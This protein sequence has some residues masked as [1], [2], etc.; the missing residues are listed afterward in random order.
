MTAAQPDHDPAAPVAVRR[1]TT[2]LV[3]LTVL[4]LVAVPVAFAAT[5]HRL[6]GP[7]TDDVGVLSG[8]T[9]EIQARLDAL[10]NATKAQLW[11]W[12]TDTLQGADSSQFATATAGASG[13]GPTDL[14]LVV[15][16]ND[17]AYGW[18]KGNDVPIS[19]SDLDGVLS[20]E[21]ESGLRAGDEPGAVIAT[22][23]GLQKLMTASGETAPPGP[24]VTPPVIEPT[25]APSSSGSGLGAI[26]VFGFIAILVVGGWLLF[27]QRRPAGAAAVA[28]IPAGGPNAD[29]AGLRTHDLEDLANRTLVETD[30]AVRDSDQEL[31]F[32][33]A[34]FGDEA[35]RPFIAAIAAARDDLKRAF[36][37][38][39][40][41]D[42]STPEDEPTRRGMLTDLIVA[43]RT[44]R[45]RLRDQTARFDELRALEQQAPAI[46]AGLPAE[47][48]A[49][50]AR[51]PA[52]QAT[53]SGL[54]EYADSNWQAVAA[55][56]DNARTRIQAVREAAA[57]GTKAVAAGTPGVAAHSARLGEDGIAQATAYL[58][59][60]DRLATELDEARSTVD[61]ALSTEEA[62]LAKVKA[63]ISAAPGGVDAA[64]RVR[65]AEGLLASAR[66]ALDPPKPDVTG[67]HEMIRKADALTDSIAKDVQ[68]AQDRQAR[69]AAR[70]VAGIRAAR[71]AVTRA[72][73]YVAGQ[74]G[75]IGTEARTRLAEASRHLEAAVAAA[76]TDTETALAEADQ[77]SQLAAQAERLAQSDYGR[78]DD[79]FRGGGFGGGGGR[80]SDVAG[81]IIG[82]IIG[83]LLSGGG[84]GRRGGMFGGGGGGFGGFGGGGG[85]FGGFG[86][87]SGGGGFGGGGGGS[88]G[89]GRW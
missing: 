55:N 18:W 29:L 59:A 28:A 23:D 3:A 40:Q 2:A 30:D 69:D 64:A 36:T 78:W 51:L 43:C 82:G 21:L 50:E 72:A 87:S 68:S 63:E 4:L 62:D 31:G 49:L 83:G 60:I 73:D 88:S 26:A 74:R 47:A 15:A 86:G 52:A 8:R 16:M 9:S 34:Q 10:Q 22:A 35:A 54:A 89:G 7:I 76:S 11:V 66:T 44:A 5:P 56:V 80:G 67:A 46:L 65:E 32:A 75:G 39:Q 25:P 45:G 38:R 70:V 57:Q 17:R 61:A 1:V 58:D 71:V 84:G 24:G 27:R 42:D 19:D 48:D 20:S 81:A 33:Q 77:A 85:G 13:L 12:F 6:A 41:L 37:L 14:L 79:P 53:L